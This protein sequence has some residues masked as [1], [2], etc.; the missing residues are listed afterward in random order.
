MKNGNYKVKIET[1]FRSNNPRVAWNGM[2]KNDQLFGEVEHS[3]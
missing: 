3:S 2:R 1:E